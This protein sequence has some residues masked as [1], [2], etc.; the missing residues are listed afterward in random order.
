M[1][2][3]C[4]CVKCKKHPLYSKKFDEYMTGFYEGFDI[5]SEYETQGIEVDCLDPVLSSHIDYDL[6]PFDF[7]FSRTAYGGDE[8]SLTFTIHN[9]SVVY[10]TCGNEELK[11]T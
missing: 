6:N 7:E 5:L 4:Y 11:M 10:A 8:E 9:D 2:T 1:K 3:I